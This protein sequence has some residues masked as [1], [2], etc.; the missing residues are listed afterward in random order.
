MSSN[1]Y[2]SRI[3]S[4]EDLGASDNGK[5][6]YLVKDIKALMSYVDVLIGSGP[7]NGLSGGEDNAIGSSSFYKTNTKCNNVDSS[8]NESVDRY[9][10][11]D[12]IPSG[13]NKSLMFGIEEDIENLNPLSLLD[14]IKHTDNK[15]KNVK[16]LCREPDGT[17]PSDDDIELDDDNNGY[18]ERAVNLEEIKDIDPCLFYPVNGKRINPISQTPC[19]EGFSKYTKNKPVQNIYNLIIG[20]LFVYILCRAGFRNNR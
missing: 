13:G 20:L 18:L 8:V 16:L 17:P 9:V 11:H 4:P 3:K 1:S 5:I 6:K 12:S 7:W 2:S 10:Y 19:R 15:C 14:G